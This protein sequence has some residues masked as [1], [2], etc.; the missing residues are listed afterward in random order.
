MMD[1][2]F[3]GAHDAPASLRLHAAHRGHTLRHTMPKPVA[4]G[5][6]V[7]TVWRENGTDLDRFKENIKRAG[8]SGILS[9]SRIP[10]YDSARQMTFLFGCYFNSS[11]ITSSILFL[12]WRKTCC[13]SSSVPCA[14]AGSTKLW[15]MRFPA[16]PGQTGHSSAAE[17]QTV[18][19][20]SKSFVGKS[21]LCFDLPEWET[22]ISLNTSFA[23]L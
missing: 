13:C 11:G 23:S 21:L 20:T 22:P 7:K 12:T 16:F 4:M 9:S 18:T 15:W 3:L 10:L 17:S 14:F 1:L 5:Y 19:T 2:C 8:H 6:L